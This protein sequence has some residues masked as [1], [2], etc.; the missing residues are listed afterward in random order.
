MSVPTTGTGLIY[1][2]LKDRRE[3]PGATN[4]LLTLA[5]A[6]VPAPVFYYV[7]L[8]NVKATHKPSY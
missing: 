5:N 1:Q 7:T 6:G 3:I 8:A 4:S 2:W